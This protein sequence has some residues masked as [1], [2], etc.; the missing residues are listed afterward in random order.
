MDKKSKPSK[1]KETKVNEEIKVKNNDVKQK[2]KK[3][4]I[5][6]FKK[7]IV[8][9]APEVID[10]KTKIIEPLNMN[11]AEKTTEIKTIN[12]DEMTRK[13]RKIVVKKKK[14]KKIGWKIFRI[15]LFVMIALII[16]FGG[17]AFGILTGI[18][19]DTE[20]VTA[21]DMALDENSTLYSANNEVI[22]ELK[23]EE[24]REIIQ[25]EDLPKFVVDAVVAIE[26]E[27]FFE[28]SGVDIKRTAAAVVSY[29]V[30][31]GKSDF[32]GSTITQQLVKNTTNDKEASWTRKVREW[33]RAISLEKVMSKEKIMEQYLNTIYMGDNASGI[34]KAAENY[35]GKRITDVN[36]AEAACLAAIIQ[37]P[38][39]Y[40]PYNGD[41]S[42]ALL[43]E[44]QKIVLSQMLKLEKIS[45]EEY[46][47]AVNFEVKF[48]KDYEDKNK[49]SLL[50][51]F[52][53]A[54]IHEVATDLAES[55][56]ITYAAAIQLLYTAGYEIYTTQDLTVQAAID[57]AYNNDK[58]FYYNNDGSF[59]D[60]SMVVMDQATGNVLGLIGSA[61]P[62]TT[63]RAWNGATQ[64]KNQP[65]STMKLLG[66]YGPAFELGVSAP[67]TGVDDSYFKLNNWVP[68]NYYYFYYGFV[69][70]RQAIAKSMNIPAI[71]T[72]QKAGVDYAWTFAKNCGLKS[73][74][75]EDKKLSSVA[76]GGLTYGVTTL[77]LCNAYATIANGGVYV[78]P[79]LYTKVVDR[80]GNVILTKESEV[81]R[82]M[83]DST[84]YMLTS[85]LESVV[86]GGTAYGYVGVKN[87]ATAGKTGNTDGD[88][89]QWFVGFTPYYT[90]ACWNGYE[91]LDRAI[92]YR[93]GIGSTYPYTC[94]PLFNTVMNSICSGK[95][96]AGFTKPDSVISAEVCKVSGLVATDACRNDIR[97]SQVGTDYFARGTVPT[98]TCNIHKTVKICNATGKLANENC[99]NTAEKSY[100]TRENINI[101]IKTSDWNA[102]I[103]TETCTVCQK[104]VVKE[105][106]PETKPGEDDKKPT[107]G[108]TTETNK[109]DDDDDDSE[110]DIY[111]KK[112]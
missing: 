83:K 2:P 85:C 100:I 37:A 51:Y 52:A 72:T 91:K 112:N 30:H 19:E 108:G 46:D 80:E 97:G 55:K 34:E 11:E 107:N 18:I 36:I 68:E 44:R 86:N 13:G 111:N 69:T 21:E 20:Q 110:V 7:K 5:S 53:D 109:D 23:G 96:A 49:T 67:G 75:E 64:S 92:G 79:K 99:T 3:Q 32:G 95:P 25:Y 106:E 82:V 16:I 89:D 15:F 104:V 22:A 76:I 71:R 31:M 94:M 103:P 24:N 93:G 45:Q 90:I 4:K 58:L 50:S 60:S 62:K 63:D 61:L 54:V 10:D 98:A 65:G 26:D 66:A 56:G 39:T 43:L 74:V 48:T 78:E 87:I 33:Y 8:K 35:F 59:M 102:M 41:E 77:E 9:K 40:N 6:L 14:G 101:P 42:R 38:S 73:L 1:E 28:H 70:C 105:P 47:E 27:R 84:A 12:N 29:V 57:S 17:I 81:K 88:R